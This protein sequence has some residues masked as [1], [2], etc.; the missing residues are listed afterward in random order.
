AEKDDSVI[1]RVAETAG[2][3]GSVR[4]SLR[5]VRPEAH[6]TDYLERNLRPVEGAVS[7]EP[8]KVLTIRQEPV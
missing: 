2:K 4:L 1:I 6:L 5:G 3:R 7:V 8:W